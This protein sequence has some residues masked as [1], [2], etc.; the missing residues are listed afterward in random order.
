MIGS[1]WDDSAGF[2][3]SAS[4]EKSGLGVPIA[5]L[6]SVVHRLRCICFPNDTRQ[7]HS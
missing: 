2:A 4:W 7:Y 5:Y 1:D 6:T 3:G